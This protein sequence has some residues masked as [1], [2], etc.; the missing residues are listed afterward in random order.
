[1]S[2]PA[3]DIL[4]RLR[5]VLLGE[6]T[7]IDAQLIADCAVEIMRLRAALGL[8]PSVADE[9]EPAPDPV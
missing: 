4:E 7:E 5:P 9:P 8:L 6:T 3:P 2:E 1:M